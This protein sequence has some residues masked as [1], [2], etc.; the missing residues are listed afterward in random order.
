[1]HIQSELHVSYI[2]K[3]PDLYDEQYELG[4]WDG[5]VEAERIARGNPESSSND[6]SKPPN[7]TKPSIIILH[8]FISVVIRSPRPLLP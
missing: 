7:S 1:M 6:S 2:S 3:L 8:E 5:Y 4:Y